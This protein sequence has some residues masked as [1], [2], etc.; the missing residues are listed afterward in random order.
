LDEVGKIVENNC[1]KENSPAK[2][3][4]KTLYVKDTVPTTR[5][6]TRED[7][8]TLNSAKRKKRRDEYYVIRDIVTALAVCH[9][10][11]PVT[12][13][14][15]ER[16]L[17]ASSPDEVALVKFVEHIGY[18]LEK[19]DQ[20]QIVIK[21]KI[22]ELE[23]YEILDCFPFSSDTKRMGIVVRY[24][25]NGLIL[26]Y[27]KGAE[28]VM[29]DKVKP[30]Q[31]S[32]LL[33]K[34]ENL[35]MEGLRT[36]VIA[37]KVMTMEEY[38]RWSAR[39]KA[40]LNDYERG[41]ELSEKVKAELE[42]NLE[43]LGVTGVEDKLQDEVEKTISSLR[44]AG[45]QVWMLTGDKIETATCISISTGLKNRSQRHFFM[46]ELKNANEV[47]FKLKDLERN[48]ENS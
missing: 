10:V 11:T 44:S 8:Q 38:E 36:L 14:D 40:A 24:K 7:V 45:I 5:E 29:K 15:G 42:N 2:D 47:D 37:Q 19:R 18:F 31:R 41:D 35:A 48:I 27:C 26:F 33:E 43:C 13:N 12:N 20:R 17:Q 9:N 30:Q 1:I 16:E 23:E 39:Y 32:Y 28:V 34:C 6:T 21:N 4:Y 3:L 46:K 25:K 22:G